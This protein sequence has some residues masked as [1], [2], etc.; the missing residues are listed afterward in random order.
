METKNPALTFASVNGSFGGSAA[1]TSAV[2]PNGFSDGS[3]A[4]TTDG[5]STIRRAVAAGT[6]VGPIG[7]SAAEPAGGGVVA[8]GAA[9]ASGAAGVSAGAAAGAGVG[10]GVCALSPTLGSAA[11]VAAAHQTR[12]LSRM[13]AGGSIAGT[14]PLDVQRF[15]PREAVSP[16]NGEDFR[17]A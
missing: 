5:V 17:G 2:L 15:P 14:T 10:A 7:G 1:G 11:S 4:T 8:A 12:D 6:G 13:E 16:S 3:F 9:D